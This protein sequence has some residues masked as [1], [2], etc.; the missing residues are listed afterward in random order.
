MRI[1]TALLTAL[2]E[3]L[4]PYK[5]DMETFWD[6][7]DGE[8]DIMDLVGDLLEQL[9]KAKADQMQCKARAD[10]YSTRASGH[11]SR[12]ET[13]KRSMLQILQATGQTKIPHAFGT[14]SL[15]KG[16]ES[17]R[18]T[19]EREIPSQLTRVTV[20]PDK[21]EIK[22]QL[23]AGVEIEGAELFTGPETIAVRMK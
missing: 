10:M 7:I 18:I 9:I 13:I 1:D 6:T 17:L 11:A 2:T 8:T 19:D 14:I 16:T 3:E 20:T 12:E 15:R 5:E 22:K 4:E 21:A 23:K